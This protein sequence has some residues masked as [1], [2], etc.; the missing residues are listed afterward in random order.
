MGG[1]L[2]YGQAIAS[3]VVGKW[4]AVSRQNILATA[5]KEWGTLRRTIHAAK[6]LRIRHT[7]GTSPGS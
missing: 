6:Y 3:M 7:D 4:S 5:L 1:S 2:K